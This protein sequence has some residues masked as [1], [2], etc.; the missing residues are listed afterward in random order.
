MVGDTGTAVH[1]LR[2]GKVA[3]AVGVAVDVALFGGLT[4]AEDAVPPLV[5]SWRNG[6]LSVGYFFALPM[7]MSFL[8]QQ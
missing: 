4:D 2:I 1:T 7:S 3:H 6:L 5:T 8:I